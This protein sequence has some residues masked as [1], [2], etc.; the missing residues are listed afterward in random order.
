VPPDLRALAA[1]ARGQGCPSRVKKKA[2]CTLH[3]HHQNHHQ[4]HHNQK[5]TT[6]TT[7]ATTIEK[8]KHK[9]LRKV[10]MKKGCKPTNLVSWNAEMLWKV[11]CF[12][13]R[14][15]QQRALPLSTD[16]NSK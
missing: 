14:L 5:N 16:S 7:A 6:T 1:P 12:E 4:I 9:R 11:L 13:M 2:E 15:E 10:Q 8:E 3:Y